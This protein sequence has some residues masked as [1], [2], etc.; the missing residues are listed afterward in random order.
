MVKLASSKLW[1]LRWP[2]VA[3][4]DRDSALIIVP[5]GAIEQHGHHLPLDTDIYGPTE[6][7]LAVA[8]EYRELGRE[9]VLVAP[10]VWWGTSPH[11]LGY[12]GTISL[13]MQTASDL[14]TDICGSLYRNGFF[15]ILLLNGH[16]GNAG[17]LSATSLRI[18]EELGFSPAFTSYW[19]LIAGALREIGDTPL[20]G[21]G[22]G[23]EMET[24]LQ[25]HLRPNRVAMELARSDLPKQ[26]TSYS[27]IDFRN[28]GP[29][30]IPWDFVRDSETG[31]MG[32]PTSATQEKGKRIA[33]AATTEVS[34][35]VAELLALRKSDFQTGRLA[36]RLVMPAVAAQADSA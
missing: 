30:A 21:M 7:A 16:G 22:H 20:G 28:P 35:L 27:S 23:C 34:R 10:P 6:L 9:V 8:E 17:V 12:P 24:S 18:S 1:E 3:E 31:T 15:R 25:L 32:D 2:E 36:D 14:V 13:R 29:V 4:I 26:M 5:T 33:E 19:T 11:H